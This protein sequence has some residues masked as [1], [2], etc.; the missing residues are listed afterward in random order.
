[1]AAGGRFSGA[2]EMILVRESKEGYRLFVHL[3]NQKL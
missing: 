3:E 2:W 1:M